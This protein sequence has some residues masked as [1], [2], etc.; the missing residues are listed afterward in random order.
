MKKVGKVC[1]V[2]LILVFS[3]ISTIVTGCSGCNGK[4]YSGEEIFKMYRGSVG[5][6][7]TYDSKG[8]ELSL[9]TCF[10]IGDNEFA[11]NYHVIKDAYSADVLI[12]NTTLDVE[13][14]LGYDEN[15]DIALFSLA[16]GSGIKALKSIKKNKEI[17]VGSVVY[18]IGSSEGY[19]LS[20]S[21]GVVSSAQREVEGVEYI[22]HTAPI[23]HGN[24]GG[25][26]IDEYG[27]VIG[28]N[29]ASAT[30]GQNLNFAIKI[31][32]I[33]TVTRETTTLENIYKSKSKSTHGYYEYPVG[34][35][36]L[37]ESSGSS[38]LTTC[39]TIYTNGTTI[40]GSLY[41]DDMDFYKIVLGAG[42]TVNLLMAAKYKIDTVNIL[43]GLLDEYKK[44]KDAGI[45]LSSGDAQ[46]LSYKNTSSYSKVFYIVLAYTSDY[47]FANTT[48][49][50]VVYVTFN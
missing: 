23:S 27:Y 8:G 35:K 21:E 32:E 40:D 26:L 10:C 3:V 19:T 29:S 14:I 5:E 38:N 33:T 50:Y 43:M 28:I 41:G 15:K 4:K 24:S 22:Q 46:I 1:L 2:G 17:S 36:K 25:P 12:G 31:E 45:M 39:Q 34:E 47:E 13:S 18:S 49:T 6:V 30:D 42:E 44:V 7:K 16:D 37:H 11:T 48:A 20:F 9:G